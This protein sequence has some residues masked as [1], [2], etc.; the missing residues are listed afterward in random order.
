MKFTP[1]SISYASA[2]TLH[3]GVLV[4]VTW[5]MSIDSEQA[6][7]PDRPSVTVSF[8]GLSGEVE[9]KFAENTEISEPVDSPRSISSDIDLSQESVIKAFPLKTIAE[10][11]VR[12]DAKKKLKTIEGPFL[13][14]AKVHTLQKV[15]SKPVMEKKKSPEQQVKPSQ[16]QESVPI[17]QVSIAPKLPAQEEV[18]AL[19]GSAHS[20]EEE[21]LSRKVAN[22]TPAGFIH[23]PKPLYPRIARRRA[24]EGIV[25]LSVTIDMQGKASAISVLESSGHTRLDESAIK[26]LEKA[27]FYPAKKGEQLITTT[28]KVS[29]RFDLDE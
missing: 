22:V 13:K 6:S 18:R 1:L 19:V 25:R 11:E 24:Q 26:A 9:S 10:P 28:K 14:V 4:G 3:V 27:K 7:M 12:V 5:Y 29:I 21:Q 8:Q 15:F 23:L 17:Q 20:T 16:R 2:I